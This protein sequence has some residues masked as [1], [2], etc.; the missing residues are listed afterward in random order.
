MLCLRPVVAGC[1]LAV[2]ACG[3][4]DQGGGNPTGALTA[5]QTTQDTAGDSASDSGG[6]ATTTGTT[7]TTTA[8]TDTTVTTT[9]TDGGSEASGTTI[10]SASVTA[11]DSSSGGV[12]VCADVGG[13]TLMPPDSCDG[14]S[15][16]TSTQVP[17]NNL[18]STSWFGCYEQD[19]G[20]IYQDPYDNCEFACGSQGLCDAGQSGPECEAGLKWFAAD[21]DRFGCGGRIRV[22]NCD[23]GNQVVL[24]TL[25]RGPNCGVE[26]DC[27]TPVLDMG[28]DAMVYLFDGNE[29]GGCEHQ[30]VVVEAVPDDTP[31][32]PV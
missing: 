5:V 9:A 20:S 8:T 30:A 11:G 16:N 7:A 19:D 24:V 1:G 10:G 23:N 12:D 3:G 14:P 28:H 31:L 29:Y 2:I 26:M 6:T 17:S 13:A 4:S 15:G 32:G 18:F 27:E 25:D 22:T 21:A